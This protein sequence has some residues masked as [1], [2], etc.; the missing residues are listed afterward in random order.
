MSEH[1][2]RI[3]DIPSVLQKKDTMCVLLER[4]IYGCTSCKNM[5][6]YRHCIRRLMVLKEVQDSWSFTLHLHILRLLLPIADPALECS[7]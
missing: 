1:M 7:M 6:I 2:N 5:T 3:L 4:N